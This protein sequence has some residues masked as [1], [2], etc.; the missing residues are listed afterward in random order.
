MV[1]KAFESFED[2]ASACYERTGFVP[3]AENCLYQSAPMDF[4][5]IYQLEIMESKSSED[6]IP[7]LIERV[8]AQTG[9]HPTIIGTVDD[10]YNY[11]KTKHTKDILSVYG[12]NI[13]DNSLQF[14]PFHEVM[15][16]LGAKLKEMRASMDE[17]EFERQKTYILNVICGERYRNEFM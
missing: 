6:I 7:D 9:K 3:L 2:A 16:D 14:R 12:I 5:K 15:H 11:E 13:R 1:E 10:V 17:K 4:V 8:E